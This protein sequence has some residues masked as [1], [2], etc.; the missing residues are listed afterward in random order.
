MQ[1][2]R[3]RQRIDFRPFEQFQAFMEFNQ[4]ASP[5]SDR[6]VSAPPVTRKKSAKKRGLIPFTAPRNGDD[7]GDEEMSSL[8]EAEL[9]WSSALGSA[10]RQ[11]NRRVIAN[12][13]PKSSES[14]KVT[15][16]EIGDMVNIFMSES[17]PSFFGELDVW[18]T[19]ISIDGAKLFFAAS[20]FMGSSG[21]AS[22]LGLSDEAFNTGLD[23]MKWITES[24]KIVIRRVLMSLKT[25]SLSRGS[26]LYASGELPALRLD[27]LSRTKSCIESGKSSCSEIEDLLLQLLAPSL[28]GNLV[29]T[30]SCLVDL[31]AGITGQSV[32]DVRCWARKTNLG[33]GLAELILLCGNKEVLLKT[34]IRVISL[35]WGSD[36]PPEAWFRP[37]GRK[38]AMRTPVERATAA[39]NVMAT[40]YQYSQGAGKDTITA[41]KQAVQLRGARREE[42]SRSEAAGSLGF[43][44]R[45]IGGELTPTGLLRELRVDNLTFSQSANP[46]MA[47]QPGTLQA[48]FEDG[49]GK[50][51]F[52]QVV[53]S[54][55]AQR[56]N[57]P[58][59]IT[60][61]IDSISQDIARREAVPPTTVSSVL[62]RKMLNF[63]K[64]VVCATTGTALPLAP[65]V[66]F[67]EDADWCQGGCGNVHRF[68][69][70]V[71]SSMDAVL[72]LELAENC[73]LSWANETFKT[74][75]GKPQHVI[76]SPNPP[77]AP[78]QQSPL[79]PAG[80]GVE[81]VRR[82]QGGAAAN[83]HDDGDTR[84]S[85]KVKP[86]DAEL[87]SARKTWLA[88]L[89]PS[90]TGD[91]PERNEKPPRSQER[92]RWVWPVS[93][94][95]SVSSMAKMR[96]KIEQYFRAGEE[97]QYVP[98]YLRIKGTVADCQWRC[99]V[100]QNA[101]KAAQDAKKQ[102]E[103]G[104]KS[105]K[106]PNPKRKGGGKGGKGGKGGV[107]KE[108][109][110]DGKK[111]NGGG[112]ADDV[113]GEDG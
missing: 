31:L 2:P 4:T 113:V 76:D 96:K 52:C 10:A 68:S 25:E 105:A 107:N 71:P 9:I 75:L 112:G 26:P 59:Q 72:Y 46:A 102:R 104:K 16:A 50:G 40:M 3:K 95:A 30:G 12:L 55:L 57:L 63:R 13:L 41:F 62:F 28:S 87:L 101:F 44:W 61:M 47:L 65:C 15:A 111:K 110:K 97:D 19:P 45:T 1:K 81:P 74:S 14:E 91:R 23:K 58:S 56:A 24:E 85:R 34:A 66:S 89:P 73:L 11:H 38:A 6:G 100:G 18:K 48:H 22:V 36:P 92:T 80:G 32:A 35:I 29:G 20:S 82:G 21:D 88:E 77:P 79:L 42:L 93:S 53:T 5:S 103:D 84:A 67:G 33:A 70:I 109:V 98:D 43:C 7:E 90:A 64:S 37:V 86:S 108:V 106:Q 78:L 39:S 54:G 51:P 94:D 8:G 83:Q 60:Y 69:G 99:G 27:M 49:A 17:P